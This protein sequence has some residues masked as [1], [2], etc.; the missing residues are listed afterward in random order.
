MILTLNLY[1]TVRLIFYLL[2]AFVQ[3]VPAAFV[4]QRN[5][6]MVCENGSGTNCV[7]RLDN[8]RDLS[9]SFNKIKTGKVFRASSMIQ[10]IQVKVR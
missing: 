9:N 10:P 6:M 1:N 8:F 3:F 4:T 5:S 7:G 2:L